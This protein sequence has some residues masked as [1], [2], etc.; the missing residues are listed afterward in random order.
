M[1]WVDAWNGEKHFGGQWLDINAPL[2]TLPVFLK[3][4]SH[5][6]DVFLLSSQH[7]E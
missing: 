5:L 4:G 2:E 3:E 1:E 6:L 7:G